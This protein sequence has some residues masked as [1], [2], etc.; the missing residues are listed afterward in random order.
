MEPPIQCKDSSHR[1]GICAVQPLCGSQ[2]Q[3]EL[4][5][6]HRVR[7]NYIGICHQRL[8]ERHQCTQSRGLFSGNARLRMAVHIRRWPHGQEILPPIRSER[9]L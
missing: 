8:C 7:R 2:Q 3:E 4:D 5:H 1:R 9:R 6:H